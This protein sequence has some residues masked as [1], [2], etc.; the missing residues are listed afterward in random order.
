MK[1]KKITIATV[2]SFLKKYSENVFINVKSRFDGMT[3]GTE[4]LHGGFTKATADTDHPAHTLGIAG[5]WFVGQSRDY[6]TPY[7]NNMLHLTGG[8]GH[9]TGIEVSNSCGRFILAVK[10]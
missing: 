2:K 10:K 4:Q 5:A 6:F 9:L 7:D 3:D 8:I 1:N